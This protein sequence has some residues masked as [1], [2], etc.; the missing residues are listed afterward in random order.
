MESK[1]AVEDL[2]RHVDLDDEEDPMLHRILGNQRLKRRHIHKTDLAPPGSRQNFLLDASAALLLASS[3]T[4][5]TDFSRRVLG[6][7]PD[8]LGILT[9]SVQAVFSVA[10]TGAFTKVGWQWIETLL[11]RIHVNTHSQSRLRFILSLVFF[12][13]ICP[14]WLW[15]PSGLAKYY[16]LRGKNL[17]NSDAS[18]ALSY[19]E[20][21]IALNPRLS[22]AHYN[23]GELLEKSYQYDQAISHYQQAIAVN[24]QDLRS[25]S[26]LARLTLIGGNAN[27]ALRIINQAPI[28]GSRDMQAL[29]AIYDQKGLAEFE[30]GFFQPA[31]ADAQLSEKSYPNAAAYCL[32]AKIYV[33]THNLAAERG[34]W[35]EFRKMQE[36]TDPVQAQAAPDCRLRAE[37]FN[38]KN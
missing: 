23:L 17:E 12:A 5:V 36:S 35:E 11:S 21:S 37:D 30:L 38:A 9:V 31:V 15:A 27:T 24:Q 7:N 2:D 6:A 33:A 10:A 29:A 18:K 19:L 4:M 14:T 16:N 20:R 26:N 8:E 34:A 3:V 32:L 28:Q 22:A 13:V 25:Y 1:P